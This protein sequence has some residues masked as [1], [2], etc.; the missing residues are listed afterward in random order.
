MCISYADM[1]CL[2]LYLALSEIVALARVAGFIGPP[3]GTSFLI[4]FSSS[5]HARSTTE[6]AF[7]FSSS[8]TL[9]VICSC[10]SLLS[11]CFCM[12]EKPAMQSVV[13]SMGPG[14]R[15]VVVSSIRPF[16]RSSAVSDLR[17]AVLVRVVK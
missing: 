7:L 9:M 2:R 17:M 10:W 3:S 14:C 15:I 5:W 11:F 8:A 4:S 6:L 13:I 12:D 1:P 16:H